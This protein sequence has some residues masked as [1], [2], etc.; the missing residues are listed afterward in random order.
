M[1]SSRTT[2]FEPKRRQKVPDAERPPSVRLSR[3]S[4]TE[5]RRA[6]RRQVYHIAGAASRRCRRWDNDTFTHEGRRPAPLLFRNCW[7]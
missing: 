4:E 5:T 2:R 7:Q 1:A 6:G 3:K